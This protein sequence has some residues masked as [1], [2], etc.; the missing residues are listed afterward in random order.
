MSLSSIQMIFWG[1]LL[2]EVFILMSTGRRVLV[3]EFIELFTRRLTEKKSSSGV[4]VEGV[5]FGEGAL[6]SF[7]AS[8]Y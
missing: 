6:C 1:I 4:R 5:L 3:S 7:F 8:E 2:L